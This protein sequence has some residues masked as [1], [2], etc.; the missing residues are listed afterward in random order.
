MSDDKALAIRQAL[1]VE[2][3]G[4]I[5]W[6]SGY[7][8]D[9]R[10]QAQAIVK[11][12]AGAELNIGP[13][14]AMNGVYI[15]EGRTTLSAN[16]MASAIQASG[17]YRYR[18]L[19]HDDQHCTIEFQAKSHSSVGSKWERIGLSSF[20]L[21]DARKAQ[22]LGKKVQM[23]EKFPRNMC[24][25]RALS[26]GAKWYTPD[27]F[28]GPIYTPDELGATVDIEGNVIEAP[29][30]EAYVPTRERD[31]ADNPSADRLITS[32]DDRVWQRW[33]VVRSEALQYGV[34]PPDPRLPISFSQ[35]VSIGNMVKAQTDDKKEQLAEQ[36]AARA[37]G[38]QQQTEMP[39]AWA[40][41]RQ[42]MAA[43]YAAGLRLRELPSAATR[44]E[45]EQRNDEI[46]Q[47]LEQQAG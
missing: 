36:D 38:V 17:R 3:L 13:I 43:A 47:A 19:E 33:E 18:V 2:R 30:E 1:G 26:N 37:A 45:V 39:S 44:A 14:A 7:W 28:G 31:P 12:L 34:V 32:A 8:Q 15:I 6:K 23:W 22:L 5:M 25:S 42:L 4:E 11:I 27:V 40:E 24:F 35:L 29:D 46:R 41:N 10:S 9:T 16:L 21:E 20:S